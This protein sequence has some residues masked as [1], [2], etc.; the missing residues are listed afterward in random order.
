M[1]YYS[2]PRVHEAVGQGRAGSWAAADKVQA[3]QIV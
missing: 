3:L 1:E 2:S